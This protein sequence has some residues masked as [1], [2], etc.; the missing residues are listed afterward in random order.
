[1]A[2]ELTSRRR[3]IQIQPFVRSADAGDRLEL[4]FVSAVSSIVII[5]SIL[6]ATGYPQLGGNGLHIAHVLP[7]GLLMLISLV[8]LFSFLNRGVKP[9]AAVLGGIGFGLFIDELG[10]FLT[11][12]TNYFFEPTIMLI[13]VIFVVLF[14]IFRSLGRLRRL[15]R[16]ESLLN[17]LELSKD[18]V[19]HDLDPRER[20]LVL[21]YLKSA[22]PQDPIAKALKS[23]MRHIDPQTGHPNHL[24]VRIEYVLHRAYLSVRDSSWFQRALIAYYII[25]SIVTIIVTAVGV[26]LDDF[27]FSVIELGR[28]IPSAVSSVIVVVGAI[29]LFRSRLK[30]YLLFRL[31]LYISIFITQ[32]FIFYQDQLLGITFLVVNLFS[33]AV[34]QYMISE[35]RRLKR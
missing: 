16:R 21:R 7:G 17:A 12:D 13:Y 19:L 3:L 22:D 20:D 25:G 11:S 35:E 27:T 1:M 5:R 23:A 18:V 29:M 31:S 32:L 9:V 14:F 6:A 34:I 30:G 33:L 15:D 4:F 8:L 24:L 26:H 28:L 2:T 10:K